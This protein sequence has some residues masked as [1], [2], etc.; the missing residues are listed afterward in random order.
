MY[1]FWKSITRL[2]ASIFM[3]EIIL[4]VIDFWILSEPKLDDQNDGGEE[5]K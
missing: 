2:S 4:A 3:S 5:C 1:I